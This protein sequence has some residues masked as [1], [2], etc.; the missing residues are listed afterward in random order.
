MDWIEVTVRT[1]T[2]GADM[3]SELLMRHGS[4]GTS[5]EDRFDAAVDADGLGRWDILDP[6]ILDAMD[7]DVLVRGYL[8]GDM[9]SRERLAAFAGA[10]SALTADAIGFDAGP[11]TVS[12]ENVRDEDWAENWK[13]Y[14]KPFRVG[15]RLVVKPVWEEFAEKPGD[16]VLE[17]DPGPAFGN[18]SHETTAMC[19]A[20]LERTIR[21]GDAVLDVG[22]G[23]GILALAAA[24]L[25]ASRVLAI[26]LDPVAVRVAAENIERNGLSGIAQA[27]GGDLLRDVDVK[28]DLVVANIIA[29]AVIHL[30][31]AVRER[32]KPGG[33]F[34]SSGII[35]DREP[36]VLAALQRAGFI[37]RRI[38][39][40]G[41]WV[42]ILAGMEA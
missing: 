36:D 28:A 38:E 30:A 21:P 18:G 16:I 32:L 12:S 11:L 2:Q 3:V 5:I 25:G 9:G 24:K 29:D 42:A 23:S 8:P 19:M 22:T 10:L 20:L 27:R 31:D 39:R 4:K 15:E 17:I 6:A 14:Y 34:V 1:N 13:Q 33:A 40:Q 26:D 35:R 41:E 37:V 7:E